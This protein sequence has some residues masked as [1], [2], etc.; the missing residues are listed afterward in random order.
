MAHLTYEES[1]RTALRIITVLAVITVIEVLLALLGKGHL[2]EGF[3]LNE[4]LMRGL[5][6]I[7]SLA[8]AYL[9]IYEFMHMK[10]EVK[11]LPLTVL[12]PT[13]LLIWGA[14]AFASD[15][16]SWK[17]N[18]FKLEEKKKEIKMQRHGANISSYKEDVYRL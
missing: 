17:K 9:I 8:K 12:L 13:S 2:I 11:M 18:R 15:G 3:Y 7:L 16:G 4:L 10:Y 1:K 14:I 5:M 6:V